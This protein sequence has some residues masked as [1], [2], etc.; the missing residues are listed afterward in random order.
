MKK[1]YLFLSLYLFIFSFAQAERA[2]LLRDNKE[3]V[4]ARLDYIQRAQNEILLETFETGDN[5][6]TFSML[7][8]L[9]KKAQSG[10]NVKFIVDYKY[11][12]IPEAF[13]Y[14]LLKNGKD[15]NG[16]QRFEIK[17]YNPFLVFNIASYTHRD[18]S[19]LLI[20]DGLNLFMG[21]RNLNASYYGAS[22]NNDNYIDLDILT[23]GAPAKSAQESF[24]ETWNSKLVSSARFEKFTDKSLAKSC[25]TDKQEIHSCQNIKYLLK[26]ALKENENTLNILY[27]NTE[28]YLHSEPA[29]ET[30]DWLL[31]GADFES[32]VFKSHEEKVLVSPESGVLTDYILKRLTKTDNELLIINPYFAPTDDELRVFEELV[33]K[34]VKIKVITNSQ[35][36]NNE[37]FARIGYEKKRK[38]LI[39]IGVELYE[40]KGPETI[41]AKVLVIDSKKVVIGSFNFDPRSSYINREVAIKLKASE[42]N[43]KVINQV[44]E[45]FNDLQNQSTLV[46]S[47]GKELNKSLWNRKESL[48][49]TIKYNFL[50]FFYP[51]YKHQI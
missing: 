16:I 6:F 17:L 34:N 18:H 12:D 14:L 37:I 7:L 44:K 3:A 25:G 27:T 29:N 50:K 32:A 11:N 40:F 5:D 30:K 13:L 26:K 2:Y 4:Q 10:V 33:Q 41:H 39:R 20:I 47:E 46:G 15:V 35:V 1:L 9:L 48:G 36:S 49:K 22:H 38:K 42:E 8:M 23:E 28:L 21:G 51:L 19:K 24:Y 31:D 43:N 45:F